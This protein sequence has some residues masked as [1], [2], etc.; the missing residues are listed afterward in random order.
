MKAEPE[1]KENFHFHFFCK[2]TFCLI[3]VFNVFNNGGKKVSN[4]SNFIVAPKLL[5][6]FAP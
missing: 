1:N 3:S 2:H 5:L 6:Y 4:P